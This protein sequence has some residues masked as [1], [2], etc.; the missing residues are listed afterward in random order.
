MDAT[1][2]WRLWAAQYTGN[3]QAI[4]EEQIWLGALDLHVWD[5][6]ALGFGKTAK[7]HDRLD[8][9]CDWALG[10]LMLTDHLDPHWC[11]AVVP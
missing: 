6:L 10:Q 4:V 9:G 3:G 7:T 5:A 8:A 2:E 11:A 1:Q